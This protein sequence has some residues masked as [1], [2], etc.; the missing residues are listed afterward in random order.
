MCP[1][2][3]AV[4]QRSRLSGLLFQRPAPDGRLG[5][6]TPRVFHG[7]VGEPATRDAHTVAVPDARVI[8]QYV[9]AITYCVRWNSTTKAQLKTGLGMFAS[10]GIPVDGLVLTNVDL[11]EVKKRGLDGQYGYA[12]DEGY[13]EA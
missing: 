13:H 2:P 9:D 12:Y 10:I 8:A 5:N 1:V 6:S 7:V 3:D 4:P 11:K